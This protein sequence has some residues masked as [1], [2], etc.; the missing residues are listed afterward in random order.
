MVRFLGL[1]SIR[2]KAIVSPEYRQDNDEEK[3]IRVVPYLNLEV[4]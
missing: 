2:P 4:A 3:M 1:K